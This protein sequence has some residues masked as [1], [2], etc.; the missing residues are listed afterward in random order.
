MSYHRTAQLRRWSFALGVSTLAMAAAAPAFAQCSPDPT[1]TNT[2]TNCTGADVD[3]LT[4]NT[5]NTQVVVASG[6]SVQP[7]SATAAIRVSASNSTISV[8]GLVDG[9]GKPGVAVIAG[10]AVLVPCDPYAGAG[11]GSCIPGTWVTSYPSASAAINVAQGGVVTGAQA[12]QIARDLSNASGYVSVSVA[13]AGTMTG[14]A[15]PAIV[16]NVA[17]NSSVTVSN[18]AGGS[19]GGIS[20][21]IGSIGNAGLI[22]GGAGSAIAILSGGISNSGRIVSSGT[23]ATVSSTGALTLTNGAG[24]TLGGSTTAVSA[25]GALSLTNEGTINGSIVSTATTGQNSVIDTRKGVINGNLTLGAGDDTLRAMFD[26][27]T[28]KIAS[29]TGTIDGGAGVDTMAIGVAGDATLNSVALPANFELLGL[30]LS[31]NASVT[32]APGFNA[33]GIAMTGSGTV[34]NQAD[35]VSS[36]PAVVATATIGPLR[37]INT[38]SITA[39]PGAGQIAVGSPTEVTNSGTITANGGAGVRVGSSLTNSGTIVATGTAAEIV[40][41]T[42]VNSG[43][44]RSTGGV[45]ATIWSPTSYTRSTNDGAII[46][47]TAG[48]RLMTATLVNNGAISGGTNGVELNGSATLMNTADGI[49]TGGVDAIRTTGSQARV[50]NA[51]TINGNV[52][53]AASTAFDSSDDIFVDTGGTV[54]GAI[55]LGGGDDQLVV[56]LATSAGRPLA[57]ATGGVDAGAGYDTLHYRVNA[58]AGTTLALTSGF[59]ALAYELDNNAALTLN[60]STPITTTI[61]LTGNG[62]VA[63]SGSIAA[64][65]RTLIDATVLTAAQRTGGGAGPTQALSIVNEGTLSLGMSQSTSFN[66]RSAINAGLADFT[67]NGAIVVVNAPGSYFPASGVFNGHIVTNAGTITLTGGGAAISNAQNVVNSGVVDAAGTSARGVSFFTSLENSGTIR[68]DSNALEAGSNASRIN[69]SGTI[70]S[71]TATAVVLGSYSRLTNEAG[72]TIRGTKAVDLATGAVVINHGTIVG[73]VSAY[74][75][76]T[77]HA[78]YVADGGTLAGNLAFGAATDVFVTFGT[79]TGV[80]GTIDGG[81]GKDLFGHVVASSRSVAL[82]GNAQIVNFEDALIH[83]TGTGTVATVSAANAFAGTLYVSGNGTV[84]NTAT[85]GGGVVSGAPYSSGELLPGGGLQTLV[86]FQNQGVI[87][88]GVSVSAPNVTNSGSIAGSVILSHQGPITLVNSGS[89]TGDAALG[90]AGDRVENSGSMTGTVLMDAGN[91]TFVQRGGGA[92]GIIDGAA[93]TDSF[94]FETVGNNVLAASQIKGFER[95]ETGGSGNLSLS[96]GA[97]AFDQVVVASD[98]T[99]AAGVSLTT[100]QLGFGAAGGRLSIMGRFAGSVT[101][102]SGNDRIDIS[103]GIAEAPVAF[104]AISDVDALRMSA[105]FATIAGAAKLGDIALSGGR[106]VGLAGSTITAPTITVGSGA[107]FGS[108]GTVNGNVVVIGTLSPGASPGTMTVNGNVSLASTSVSVFEIT[109]T[110]SDKLLVNGNLSIAQGATLQLTADQTVK[111]GQTLDLIAVTGGIT[112]SFTNILRSA[113]LFGA[114]VQDGDSISLLGAFANDPTFTPQVQGSIAYVNSVLM[115]GQASAGLLSAAAQLATAS[116]TSDAVAFGRLTPEAYASASQLTVE[117]GLVLADAGRGEAFATHR[118]TPGL[119]T[120]ASAL[121]GT[122]TLGGGSQGAARARTNSYGFLGGIGWGGSDWSIG[123]FIGY[124]DSRQTLGAIDARTD[125]NGVVAG[126]HGRWSNGGFGLK[127]TIAYDGSDATTRRAL[128]GGT[129]TSDY[130]LHGW[131]ADTSIDYTMPLGA[132]WIARPSLGVTTIR[133]SRNRVVE[134][135]GNPFL[136]DVARRRDDAV[137]VDG[138]VTLRGG[139]REDATVRPYLSVGLR[140]QAEGRTPYAL[141]ALGGGGYGL[142]AVGASHAPALAT[143]TLGSD[144]VLSPRLVLFGAVSGEIGDA[145]RRASARTGLR[146]AF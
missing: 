68:A 77:G 61:G 26:T 63:L 84:V 92:L 126:I 81:A 138:A 86:A 125:A 72:G 112:G 64:N 58:D 27:A 23:A 115:S 7:G 49:V 146:L 50:I 143:G 11:V 22:D 6:A 134:T 62:T 102:G 10:P 90:T 83:A 137:F 37:F 36:G 8:N 130:G 113:S 133:L 42:L 78:T 87:T 122:G 139:M 44:I 43:T 141:A 97:F 98:L 105:G 94:V 132:N 129:A 67:N 73:D 30:D 54:N 12:L 91:D 69:N 142:R 95:L 93:G 28:G 135:G 19:I 40:F 29:I 109:S 21:T 18:L 80:S 104:G 47:A 31:N 16:A 116:G 25:G 117:H 56:D 108:A 100:P 131:T 103:G 128:P 127:A 13:N 15:G 41:G 140:Y 85:I 24:A 71:R 53:L 107:T 20:G 70:E 88:G 114:V 52:N 48:V 4:V 120:F 106:L 55:R 89:I 45:G 14:T 66:L 123:G 33:A 34:I 110:V 35:L 99:I 46:G 51:G 111:P 39:S 96:G 32:L 65:D 38:G 144:I 145:D 17:T 2:T 59:E 101:G 76:S 118:D 75:L 60:A 3:G 136:L 57:G 124:L 82:D 5:A 1:A 119:F 9:A 121:A 79:D 74:A